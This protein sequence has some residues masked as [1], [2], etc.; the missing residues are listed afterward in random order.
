MNAA[1]LGDGVNG[2]EGFGSGREC[3]FACSFEAALV[4]VSRWVSA[5]EHPGGEAFPN[6]VPRSLGTLT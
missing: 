2:G 1:R 3:P 4:I 5:S 6:V